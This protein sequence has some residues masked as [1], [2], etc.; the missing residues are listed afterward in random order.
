MVRL[1]VRPKTM[2][3]GLI[4]PESPRW[5][6]GRLWFSD[7]QGHRLLALDPAG[8]LEEIGRYD[9]EPSG[10]GFLPDGT[11]LLVMRR[12]RVIV[13]VTPSGLAIHADLKSFSG[14]AVGYG[15]EP[16]DYMLN[17]M[18]VDPLGRAYVDKFIRRLSGDEARDLDEAILLVDAN[19][20]AEVAADNVHGPN[21]MAITPDGRTLILAEAASRVLTAFDI[22]SDGRL[23]NR[24]LFADLGGFR[25]DGICL[26]TEGAVWVG[27]PTRRVAL[28]VLD[29]GSV[30]HELATTERGPLACCFG[31]P[32]RDTL[33]LA[34]SRFDPAR[35][36]EAEGFIDAYQVG[37]RG[38]G[39]P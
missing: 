16:H 33:Y 12:R 6:A 19:G 4:W 3:T 9:D 34:T 31:G 30:T 2:A 10:L 28:R 22:A 37:F 39:L 14:S 5:H 15:E 29:G 20:R 7:I 17:D 25:P 18:I 13:R 35:R 27:S 26:D 38:A 21:G 32:D 11:P 8:A 1:T 23:H 36:A 24:R